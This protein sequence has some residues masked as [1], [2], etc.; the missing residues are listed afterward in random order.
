MALADSVSDVM[1]WWPDEL[2]RVFGPRFARRRSAAAATLRLARAG[3]EI[4]LDGFEPQIATDPTQI[5][6]YLEEARV[7]R[8]SSRSV[9][10]VVLPE[11]HL[12][13]GLAAIRLPRS[14]LSAMALLDLQS[15]TPFDPKDFFILLPAFDER[16]V[17]SSYY[18]VRRSA[19]A[20]VVA[21]L[22]AGG[23]EVTSLAMQTEAGPVEIDRDGLRE[24]LGESASARLG[25]RV[26]RVG[27]ATAAVGLVALFAAAH[28]R[29]ATAADSV[30]VEVDLAERQVR[31]LRGILA[32]RDDKIAQI[33][34]VRDQK[35]SLVPFASVVE[36]MSRA[37]PDNTWLTE[38][39]VSGDMVRFAGFSASA[40][41]LI[42]VLEASPMF[43]AP[44][45]MEPVVRAV[46]QEGERFS[47][48]MK[49]ESGDG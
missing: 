40:A 14:R 12:K 21:A 6:P 47:I 23:Y 33:G 16:V 3:T 4:S 25:A 37:I 35:K 43:S 32:E 13:R 7:R 9:A 26:T 48:A 30:A 29:Y 19:L 44:T 11:R 45:F 8:K 20:P 28:W 46:N 41:A 22:K 18:T 31:Q 10:I 17:D 38:L 1:N 49:I 34:A 39:S 2:A 24:V 42:P 5:V 15:S 36:E 27:L